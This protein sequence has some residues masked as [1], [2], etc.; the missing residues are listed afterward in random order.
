MSGAISIGTTGLTASQKEMDV[1]SNNLANS[2]TL[3]F[4]ASETYFS[5]M[6]NQSMSSSSAVGQGVAVASVTT[7]FSQGSFETTSSATD[8]AIDGDGFF[9]VMDKSG[10]PL[11]TR[12]GA[13]HIDNKGYLVDDNAYKVQGVSSDNKP[14]NISGLSGITSSPEASTAV[15]IGANLN[16]S[17]ANGNTFNFTQT[18]YDQQGTSHTLNVTFMK[19][20]AN[21]WSIDA[22]LDNT[23]SGKTLDKDSVGIIGGLKFGTDGTLSGMY[24]G[25]VANMTSSV[26]HVANVTPSGA[27]TATA[28]VNNPTQLDKSADIVL[29]KGAAAAWTIANGGYTGAT[30]AQRTD[31]TVVNITPSGTGTATATVN[32]PAK[33]NHNATVVLTETGAGTWTIASGGYTGATVTPSTANGHDYLDVDL[34]GTGGSDITFD[35]GATTV[36]WTT[37]DTLTFATSSHDY[38]DVDVDGTGGADITFDLGLTGV[39]WAQNDTLTFDVPGVIGTQI[40]RPG[41]LYKDTTVA[42]GALT[43][44]KSATAGVWNV[45][46]DGGYTGATAKQVTVGTNEH[47]L[48]DLDGKSDGTDIDFNLGAT[49]GNTWAANDTVKFDVNETDVATQ[50]INL[51][52]A[53]FTL[54]S[55]HD[56]KITWYTQT[57]DILP[58]ATNAYTMTSYASPSVIQSL[59]GDGS[60]TGQLKSLSVNKSG[61]IDGIFTN[62][63]T[64]KKAQ[65]CLV[66]F[67]DPSGLKKVGNYFGETTESG[68]AVWNK[69][70]TFGVGE[71]MSNSLETS[72]TD[73]AK[74]FVNM[75]QAQRAYQASAKSIT[76]SDQM[77]TVLMNIKQ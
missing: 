37:N 1:I 27:G 68:V 23:T 55:K 16:A 31:G 43:L 15:S 33:L 3:G 39:G 49:T 66:S 72:N 24:T 20:A 52:F 60:I 61:E 46:A 56:G 35:L 62:G 42:T 34:D 17:E 32:N 25:D 71:I 4:K 47:L 65:L 21:T 18:V 70:G 73:V 22:T 29:T 67:Y 57:S 44:T 38:L 10:A 36:G 75:I 76:T 74:E 69:P 64:E 50:D 6:L 45:T 41:Q 12:A 8:L 63:K 77:L 53:G 14:I 26:G 59:Y 9:W 11:Y 19:A 5:S 40:S 7:Q 51:L 2:N 58:D 48:V 54:G 30:V 13:F 28:T